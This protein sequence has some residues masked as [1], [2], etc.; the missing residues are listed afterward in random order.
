MLSACL[1]S[2]KVAGL[3]RDTF[4]NEFHLA[5]R[6]LLGFGSKIYVFSRAGWTF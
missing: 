1:M 2:L 3:V 4:L 5:E 6:K